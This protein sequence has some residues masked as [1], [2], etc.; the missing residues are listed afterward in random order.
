MGFSLH[1]WDL[2]LTVWTIE[3]THKNVQTTAISLLWRVFINTGQP[4]YANLN[5]P[6]W[7]PCAAEV[8][9]YWCLT[10]CIQLDLCKSEVQAVLFNPLPSVY[11]ILVNCSCAVP[12]TFLSVQCLVR[13]QG[14]NYRWKAY[15]QSMRRPDLHDSAAEIRFGFSPDVVLCFVVCHSHACSQGSGAFFK[16][17]AVCT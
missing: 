14:P 1:N 8:K 17:H 15:T 2:F 5:C 4:L 16:L 13:M 3:P 7:V 9:H 11:E 6:L 10:H 12:L